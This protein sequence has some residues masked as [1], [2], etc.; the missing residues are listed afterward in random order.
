[1]TTPTLVAFHQDTPLTGGEYRNHAIRLKMECDRVGWDSHIV[2]RQY[3][4]D[5][6][7]IV[8]AK[9]LFMLEMLDTLTGPI[10]YLD[11]D[12]VVLKKWDYP[13][14]DCIG[15]AAK[16]SG[17]PYGHVHYLPNTQETRDFLNAWL[18]NLE[19]W[20][21]GDHSAMWVTM[22]ERKTRWQEIPNI[23]S[24]IRHVHSQNES[25]RRANA[26]LESMGWLATVGKRIARAR[27]HQN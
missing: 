14:W 8:K 4:G 3:G 11:V 17:L 26:R 20:E 19:G 25:T 12:S 10:V 15:W 27:E 22:L 9:P 24:R 13:E 7:S 18:L 21:G 23:G 5:Y 6:L 16:P 2:H 1:M